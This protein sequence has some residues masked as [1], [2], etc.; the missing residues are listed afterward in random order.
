MTTL[1]TRHADALPVLRIAYLDEAGSPLAVL[2]DSGPDCAPAH[3]MTY[4]PHD[5]H[6]QAHVAYLAQL[7]PAS[8]AAYRQLHSHLCARYSDPTQGPAYRLGIAPVTAAPWYPVR[9]TT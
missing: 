5:Q 3:L 4:S 2:L 6:N 7:P 8:P 9:P 1:P